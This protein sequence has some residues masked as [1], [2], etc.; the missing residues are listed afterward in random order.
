M[1]PPNYALWRDWFGRIGVAFLLLGLVWGVALF[2]VGHDHAAFVGLFLFSLGLI[3]AS[4]PQ[5]EYGESESRRC[6][7]CGAH[8]RRLRPTIDESPYPDG[9]VVCND[10]SVVDDQGEVQA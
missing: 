10:C 4:V 8:T 7:V 6:D 3:L 5:G 1:N 9:T 2:L